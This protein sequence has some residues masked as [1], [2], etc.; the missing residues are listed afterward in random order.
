MF[1][2]HNVLAVTLVIFSDTVFSA[3]NIDTYT[4]A[5]RS[6]DW[7]IFKLLELPASALF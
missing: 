2:G 7:K 5:P 6:V 1:W 3:K 4:G